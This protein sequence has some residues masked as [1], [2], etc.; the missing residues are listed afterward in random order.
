MK[1]TKYGHVIVG[2]QIDGKPEAVGFGFETDGEQHKTFNSQSEARAASKAILLWAKDIIEYKL[3]E[4][5][6][7]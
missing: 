6:A 2:K 7:F 4:L 3:E 5:E 1:I